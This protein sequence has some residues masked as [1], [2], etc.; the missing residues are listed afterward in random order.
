MTEIR[1]VQYIISGGGVFREHDTLE[2]VTHWYRYFKSQ[3]RTDMT[4]YKITTIREELL[5]PQDALD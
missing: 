4:I 2:E 3:G 5:P 1:K